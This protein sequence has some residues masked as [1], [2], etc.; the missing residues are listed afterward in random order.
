[1]KY[2]HTI[3]HEGKECNAV[4]VLKELDLNQS[5]YYSQRKKGLSAQDAFLY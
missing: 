1:M 3:I 4:E 2:D 5:V